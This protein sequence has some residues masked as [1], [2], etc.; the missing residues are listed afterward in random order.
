MGKQACGHHV[1]VMIGSY[2]VTEFINKCKD[3]RG[4]VIYKLGIL[5]PII[6]NV[7]SYLDIEKMGVIIQ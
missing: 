4:D 7:S 2:L 5:I 6:E 1:Q 3:D